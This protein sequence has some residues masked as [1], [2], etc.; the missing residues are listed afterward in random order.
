MWLTSH[1]GTSVRFSLSR[2][3]ERLANPSPASKMYVSIL[4]QGDKITGE[5]GCR[6]T[7]PWFMQLVLDPRMNISPP[8]LY[9]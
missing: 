2:L 6:F 4:L 7:S 9:G 3:P 8:W 1:K 5:I